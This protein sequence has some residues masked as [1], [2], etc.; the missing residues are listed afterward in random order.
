MLAATTTTDT[1]GTST[2]IVTTA[3]VSYPEDLLGFQFNVT[4]SSVQ[5][6]L[7]LVFRKF[8]LLL[9]TS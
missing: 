7:R 2:T 9:R 8:Y 3:A 6:K 5:K 1:T 4:Y